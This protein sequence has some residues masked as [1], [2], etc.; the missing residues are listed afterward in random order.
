MMIVVLVIGIIVDSLFFGTV[1][2]RVRRNRGLLS[3]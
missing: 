2:R 3:P 1:E